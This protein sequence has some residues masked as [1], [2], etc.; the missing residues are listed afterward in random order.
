M[1]ALAVIV[2]EPV[3]APV[4]AKVALLWP[5]G[6]TTVAGAGR[7]TLP[8]P[9]WLSVTVKPPGSAGAGEVTVNVSMVP[10]CTV[11]VAG[12]RVNAGGVRTVSVVLALIEPDVAVI[13]VVPS[14][15]AEATPVLLILATV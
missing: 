13:V 14:A 8:V 11:A 7:V 2:T 6:M 9:D 15:K 4:T 10:T 1:G 5:S 12:A 3:V